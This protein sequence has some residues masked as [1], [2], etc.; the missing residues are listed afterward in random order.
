VLLFG[1]V[2]IWQGQRVA[3]TGP[4]AGAVR[5]E[6]QGNTTT[7][8]PVP[9]VQGSTPTLTNSAPASAQSTPD[10]WREG[11]QYHRAGQFDRAW[12]L[13]ERAAR[14]GETEAQYF[15]AGM[16]LRGEGVPKDLGLA[17]DWFAQA[18]DAGHAK[19]QTN[20]GIMIFNGMGGRANP[21]EA[22]TW[23]ERAARQNLPEAQYYL[24][25][26]LYDGDAG[27][28]DQP[29]G[30]DWLRRA[31]RQGQAEAQEVLRGAGQSW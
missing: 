11:V 28:H 13:L 4:S 17:R 15:V 7:A 3:G 9:L 16:L 12:P 21:A 25:V 2:G 6:Q 22:L 31:A 23:F 26:H 18:A 27:R 29:G 24:G 8:A 1:A 5:E 19:A 30:L 10:S 20:L 14:A